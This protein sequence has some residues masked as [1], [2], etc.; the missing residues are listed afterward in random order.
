MIAQFDPQKVVNALTCI[1]TLMGIARRVT[2]F[3][4][5]ERSGGHLVI[6]NANDGHTALSVALGELT[7]D[8]TERYRTNAHEK[9]G[10]LRAQMLTYGHIFSRQSRNPDANQ[11]GGAVL[12]GDWILS[13]SGFPEEVDEALMVALGT[14]LRLFE[15]GFDLNDPLF[16]A[17]PAIKIFLDCIDAVSPMR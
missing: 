14:R 17:N 4:S 10:R 16:Q 11:Y 8:Q 7:V 15:D 12:A 3:Q 6:M 1:Y 13:F 2:A 9:A 5:T